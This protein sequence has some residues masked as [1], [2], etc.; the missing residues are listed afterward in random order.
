MKTQQTIFV[1]Q[2]FV[3]ATYQINLDNLL[4]IFFKKF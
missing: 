3:Y 1:E 2:E 4:F